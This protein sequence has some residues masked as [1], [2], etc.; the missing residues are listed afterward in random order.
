[1]RTPRS[2]YRVCCLSD[3]LTSIETTAP[4]CICT[5]TCW[6]TR[7]HTQTHRRAVCPWLLGTSGRS[8]DLPLSRSPTCGN[9]AEGPAAA[10]SSC[11]HTP[12]L[13][14]QQQT[15]DAPRSTCLRRTRAP[16]PDRGWTGRRPPLRSSSRRTS[17]RRSASSAGRSSGW[18]GGSP[19]PARWWSSR[20]GA[21]GCSLPLWH[22]SPL[23]APGGV[24]QVQC[25]VTAFQKP[26]Y[27]HRGKRDKV[28]HKV[29][30]ISWN[31]SAEY[32]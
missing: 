9:H 30:L 23:T 28:E 3:R 20:C 19:S 24:K 22:C 8:L 26:A 4:A 10:G 27:K 12:A 13:L 5:N 16:S 18:A 7:T 25:V 14:L 21:A 29:N 2:S 15:N 32:I 6:N 1:M 17:G 31:L 11:Q